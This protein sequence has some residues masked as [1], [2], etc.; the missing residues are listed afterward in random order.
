MINAL[1]LR[2]RLRKKAAPRLPSGIACVTRGCSSTDATQCEYRDRYGTRCDLAGCSIHTVTRGDNSYC[3]R[4]AGIVDAT[5]APDGYPRVAPRLHERGPSLVN[6][7]ASDLDAEVRALLNGHLRRTESVVADGQ[8]HLIRYHNRHER[9]ERSW[10]IV[11]HTGL[12]LKVTIYVDNSGDEAVIHVS[13]GDA[14]VAAVVPPWIADRRA[15]EAVAGTID[16]ARRQRF[17]KS[18]VAAIASGITPETLVRP[19]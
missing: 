15:G 10:R 14:L 1:G 2:D 5:A 11:D 9:W 3:R 18:L 17:N 19:L 4:H 16:I 6:W 13:V 12:V 8:V 7:V